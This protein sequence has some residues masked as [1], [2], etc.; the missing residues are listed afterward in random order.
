MTASTVL[1]PFP[2]HDFDVTEV[3]VPWRL[4]VDAGHRV[5]FATEN[6]GRPAAD[7]SC[8]TAYSSARL[9]RVGHR[10]GRPRAGA[11]RTGHTAADL[12]T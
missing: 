1:I 6:G 10:A 8:W 3:A 2:D 5:V 11:R 9:R 7:P 4:L 12:M